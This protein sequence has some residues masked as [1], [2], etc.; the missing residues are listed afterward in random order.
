MESDIYCERAFADLRRLLD[1]KTSAIE[2]MK[3]RTKE[4][5]QI[6]QNGKLIERHFVWSDTIRYHFTVS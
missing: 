2:I 5:V 3:A 4:F 1:E 6:L